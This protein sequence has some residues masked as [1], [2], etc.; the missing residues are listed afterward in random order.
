M[1]TYQI[2]A[3][4][5]STYKVACFVDRNG[6]TDL[7]LSDGTAVDSF[8]GMSGVVVG[9]QSYSELPASYDIVATGDYKGDGISDL[10]LTRRK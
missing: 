4:Y 3:T 7:R 8:T 10:P 6:T 1:I 9:T 5:A 2:L